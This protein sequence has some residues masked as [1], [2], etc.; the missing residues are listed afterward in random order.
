MDYNEIVNSVKKYHYY[1]TTQSKIIHLSSSNSKNEAKN[2]AL[3]KLEPNIDNLIGKKI[4]FIK[5]KSV[6]DEYLKSKNSDE[7][8]VIG[9]PVLIKFESGIIINSKKIKNKDDNVNNLIYL[10]NKYIKKNQNNIIVDIKN[11]IN[12]YVSGKLNKGILSMNI[13]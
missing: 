2:L 7:L 12:K 9:G 4:L 13:L 5:I 10:S 11:I 3:E 6:N 1:V 8:Q